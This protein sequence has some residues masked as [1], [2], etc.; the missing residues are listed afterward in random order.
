MEQCVPGAWLG[1]GNVSVKLMFDTFCEWT[2]LPG[3]HLWGD[4]LQKY[5]RSGGVNTAKEHKGGFSPWQCEGMS[6]VGTSDRATEEGLTNS[7]RSKR[8]GTRTCR[9]AAL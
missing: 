2:S 9:E 8:M 4:K 7:M 5:H 1:A 6:R 3:S